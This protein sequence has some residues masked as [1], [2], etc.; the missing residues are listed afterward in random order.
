MLRQPPA[1]RRDLPIRHLEAD[2]AVVGGGWAGVCAA[3]TAARAGS[4]VVLVQDRPVLGGNASSEI[5]MVVLGATA[6]GA[7]N[8][9]WAREGGLVDELLLENV[10][11]NPQGNAVFGDSLLLDVVHCEPNVTL[12][13]DTAVWDVTKSSPER[14]EAVRGFS[15]LDQ[16]VYEVRAPLFCDASGD[17]IVGFLAGAA[18]RMGAEEKSEFDEPLA[19]DEAYGSLLGHT[20]Y[21]RTKDAGGPVPFVRPSFAIADVTQ[22]ARWER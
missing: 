3:V 1:D 16:T 10:Y 14:I 4:R 7:N 12:L 22:I 2:L 9:R 20:I 8:N 15:A 18:F 17:G 6:S 21:F 19:P 5:R 13:L 11:R